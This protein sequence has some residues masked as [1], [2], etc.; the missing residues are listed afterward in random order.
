MFPLCSEGAVLGLSEQERTS[1]LHSIAE[2]VEQYGY[3][4][5]FTSLASVLKREGPRCSPLLKDSTLCIKEHMED[6]IKNLFSNTKSLSAKEDLL[7][8]LRFD[9]FFSFSYP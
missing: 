7:K 1:H 6:E 8:Q 9:L 3:T 5:H 4:A 2:L